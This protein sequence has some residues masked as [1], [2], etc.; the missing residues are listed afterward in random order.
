MTKED[1]STKPLESDI[2]TKPLESDNF[3]E[4][5]KCYCCKAFKTIPEFQFIKSTQKVFKVCHECNR[6]KALI[7]YHNNRI[8]ILE[9][10][11]TYHLDKQRC[12]CGSII[13]TRSYLQ[14]IKTK[15]HT[16]KLS[17]ITNTDETNI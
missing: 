9:V 10:K 4:T 5:Y 14:H 7:H 12:S 13:Q 15:K 3:P 17:L 8:A 2:S 1:I 16:K 11:K 6:S